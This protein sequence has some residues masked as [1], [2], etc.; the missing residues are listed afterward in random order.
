MKV[1]TAL[2][3]L[4]LGAGLWLAQDDKWQRSRRIL[5]LL[6]VVIAG[7]TLA[8]Y[9][10]HA[11]FGIDQLLF[12]D[13]R[14]S[15][16][17]AYP[18][19]MAIATAICFLFLGLAVTFLGIRKA[20]ALRHT[21]VALCFAFSVV[22]L[23]GYLYGAKALYSVT[24]FSTI[25]PHTAAG[26]FAA[27][28]AYFFARPH[29]G[30]VSIAARDTDSGLLL[31]TLF[32][33]IIVVPILIGWLRLEGQTANLYD[34]QFGVALLVLV[35]I[36]CLTALTV[37]VAQ[38]MHRLELE[39]SR[40][41]A[42]RSRSAAIVESSDDAIIGADINGT[43][44]DWNQGAERLFGYLA[45]EAIGKSISFLAP[46]GRL[47]HAQQILRKVM[48]GEVVKNYET[49]RQRKDGTD[50]EISLTACPIVDVEGQV[51]G[52][53]GIARDIT[54]HKLA[55]LALRELN[56]S[57]EKQ[58]A[59]TESRE[60]LLRV[61]VKNVPAAVAM[62]D[63][64]MRYVQVS[65]RWRTDY[66]AGRE[67]VLGHSHYE[68][69]PDQPERWKEVHCRALQGETVR[70]D[71]D[72][73]DGQDGSHWA[74]WEVRPWQNA[75]GAIGGI[76]ILAE[77]IT[78]R[79][80]MEE[81]ISGLNRKL[82]QS[83]EQERT[84][85]ARE[86]H[87]D[88]SQ[89]LALLAVELDQCD[90]SAGPNPDLHNYLDQAK[91]HIAEIGRDVQ[92]LSHQLHSSKLEYLGLVAAAKSFTKEIS[93]M[94]NVRIDFTEDGVPRTLPN[95]VSLSLFRILQQAVHNALEHSGAKQIEVRMWEQSHELHLQVKDLGKGFDLLAAMQGAGLGLT[96]MRERV[97]LVNGNISIDS[98]PMRGTTIHVRVPLTS[99]QLEKQAG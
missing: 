82:I 93:E 95:E 65:D 11:N 89:Q 19:R 37:L 62:L 57:L 39:R 55:E 36:G 4:C 75:S 43:I 13:T 88:V 1:N 8:E 7:L 66:L 21:L 53:S 48:N 29:E 22:A 60:E 59:V 20:I 47:D 54:E 50:V 70:A 12:R 52:A 42:A 5:G 91:R 44:S 78:R 17:S 86:L 35:S 45:S 40:G 81:A 94:N 63:R 16:F 31:R 18:G 79:K 58:A 23:C 25:S 96:S 2:S 80:Q 41:E 33:A 99:G 83:Q 92:S 32:P 10:L 71:E 97:R 9:G 56:Q 24:S 68:M 6:V 72:R 73:W 76:L 85:I 38:S 98:K 3:F 67:Q 15:S 46:A 34:T 90:Q 69:F 64:E 61:F 51:I 14:I 87:D 26:L 74:R 84:R 28:L 77:D 30:I 27:C 49:V